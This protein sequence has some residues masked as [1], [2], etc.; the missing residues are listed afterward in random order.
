MTLE[1]V[2]NQEREG[3]ATRVVPVGH[4]AEAPAVLGIRPQCCCCL[5]WSLW[6][7][8]IL[9]PMP[10]W[11]AFWA[12]QSWEQKCIEWAMCGIM[13]DTMKR[14]FWK[15]TSGG[16]AVGGLHGPVWVWVNEP[17]SWSRHWTPGTEWQAPEEGGEEWETPTPHIYLDLGDTY[18]TCPPWTRKAGHKSRVRCRLRKT[19]SWRTSVKLF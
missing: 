6:L 5:G 17:Q 12:K 16:C 9:P 7:V 18:E 2:Q 19:K 14:S 13:R 4:P 1:W 10:Q 15:P 8:W 11:A 3:R